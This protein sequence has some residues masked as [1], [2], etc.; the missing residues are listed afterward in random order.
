MAALSEYSYSGKPLAGT[1]PRVNGRLVDLVD[2]SRGQMMPFSDLT[3]ELI[4]LVHDEADERGCLPGG[5]EAP[6]G[7]LFGRSLMPLGC[8]W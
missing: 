3:E 4:A 1:A 5:S 2:L 7:G 6:R 8:G